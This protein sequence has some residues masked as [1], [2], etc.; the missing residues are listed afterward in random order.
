MIYLDNSATTM[1]KPENV[2]LA[3]LSAFERCTNAGRGGYSSAMQ[4]AEIVFKAR[5]RAAE[6]FGAEDPS[7]IVFT[8]NAT[9][10]LNIAI[11]GLVKRGNCVISGYEHNSVLRPLTA[12]KKCGVSVNIARGRLF[13][14]EDMIKQ[15]EK[16]IQKDTKLAVCTHMSNVFGY[17]LP[18]KEIDNVCYKK[19]LP[20]VV[21]ASQSAGCVDI[22]LSELRATRAICA[23]GHKGLYGPQGTGILICRNGEE[24]NTLIEGGTGSLSADAN[25]PSFMPDRLE[26]GTQNVPGI[27]GLSEGIEFVLQKGTKSVFNHI[28]GLTESTVFGLSEI[29]GIKL[30]AAKDK[31]VQGGVLSFLI[32]GMNPAE[33]EDCL[34]KRDISVRS[35]M[36]CAPLA[37]ETAGTKNG[38]VR[39]S[40]SCFTTYE[41]I[42]MFIENIKDIVGKFKNNL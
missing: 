1:K 26:C 28:A 38:T 23:P 25:Q 30:Y 3:M 16:K 19:G 18:I 9:H 11:K 36:Q 34:S 2:K 12:M 41:E 5:E 35:G 15:F 13:D 29:P 8:H 14:C 21:D 17:I 37:H 39:V 40:V 24:F 31:S 7:Q 20:L 22:K 42:H 32:D 27:A 10:S 4:A 6:L 33:I